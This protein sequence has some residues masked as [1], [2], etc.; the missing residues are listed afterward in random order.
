MF[1]GSFNMYTKLK[2]FNNN[3]IRKQ[4]RGTTTPAK[5]F[6]LT[7]PKP[8]GSVPLHAMERD[9]ILQTSRIALRKPEILTQNYGITTIM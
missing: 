8:P 9:M 1:N 3:A 7:L 2:A 4:S 5:S 6:G